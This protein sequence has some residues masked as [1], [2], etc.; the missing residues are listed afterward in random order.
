MQATSAAGNEARF[1]YTACVRVPRFELLLDAGFKYTVSVQPMIYSTLV[2]VPTT[3]YRTDGRPA[4]VFLTRDCEDRILSRLRRRD[5]NTKHMNI[6]VVGITGWGKSSAINR[7]F[8]LLTNQEFDIAPT[9]QGEVSLTPHLIRYPVNANLTLY[10]WRGCELQGNDV[11]GAFRAYK[12]EFDCVIK[13]EVAPHAYANGRLQKEGVDVA[14]NALDGVIFVDKFGANLTAVDGAQ[15]KVDE[16]LMLVRRC[17]IPHIVMM[18]HLD[19][20]RVARLPNLDL[21]QT[22]QDG[23]RLCEYAAEWT[24]DKFP[25]VPFVG[26]ADSEANAQHRR[27]LLNALRALVGNIDFARGAGAAAAP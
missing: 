15:Q 24:D 18:S 16:L 22:P 4:P 23:L 21:A 8:R 25:I 5:P 20:C 6:G 27:L 12:T 1:S 7:I 26:A 11:D 19:K 14:K 2:G 10:D 17:G 3:I 13:G 9:G